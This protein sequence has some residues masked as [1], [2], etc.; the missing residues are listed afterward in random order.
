[1]K[2]DLLVME[3]VTFPV[4]V[5]RSPDDGSRFQPKHVAVKKLIKTSGECDRFNEYVCDLVTPNGSLV[6]KLLIKF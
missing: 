1:M 4:K 6:L 3:Y 2:G 5:Y